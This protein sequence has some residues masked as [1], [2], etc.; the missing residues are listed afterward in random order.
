MVLIAAIA[1][2][3][4]VLFSACEKEKKNAAPAA[5]TTTVTDNKT[6]GHYPDPLWPIV[7]GKLS[8]AA[9][10]VVVENVISTDR[11]AMYLQYAKDYNFFESCI[12]LKDYI[13]EEAC[14]GTVESFIHRS[15]VAAGNE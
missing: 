2:A 5:E 15:V 8:T 9:A 10:P 1:A 3:T 14:D 11:Q 6:V 13:D 4:M 12:T 7:P